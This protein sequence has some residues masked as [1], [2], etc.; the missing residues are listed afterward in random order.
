MNV[1]MLNIKHTFHYIEIE[2][3]TIHEK[4]R[5]KT[6]SNKPLLSVLCHQQL[7]GCKPAPENLIIEAKC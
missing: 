6:K 1:L 5:I 2:I 4:M 7:K 3:M